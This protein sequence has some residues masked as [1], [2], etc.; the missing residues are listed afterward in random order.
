MDSI[1][2]VP[3]SSIP[4]R[5]RFTSRTLRR[6][7]QALYNGSGGSGLVPRPFPILATAL[8]AGTPQS[9]TVV[10]GTPVFYRLDTPAGAG[11][12]RLQLAAPNGSALAASLHPQVSIFRLPPGAP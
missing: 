12:V 7:Y 6:L 9:A 4:P 2:G 8:T 1:P 5:D 3:K 10:P 11:S